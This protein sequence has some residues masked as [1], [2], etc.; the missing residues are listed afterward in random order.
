MDAR[1]SRRRHLVQS[2]LQAEGLDTD[3]YHD[4]FGTRVRDDFPVELE[5]LDA[6]GWL[7]DAAADGPGDRLRLTPEGLAHSDAVGPAF[8]SPRAAAAMAEYRTW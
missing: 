2:L 1:E 3:G 7:A 6:R 8:F 5:Q 4:R